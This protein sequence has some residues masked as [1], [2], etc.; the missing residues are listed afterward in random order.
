MKAPVQLRLGEPI[1]TMGS[2][3]YVPYVA[4]AKTKRKTTRPND[5]GA[6]KREAW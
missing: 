2:A 3:G 6:S 4:M 5:D 1:E